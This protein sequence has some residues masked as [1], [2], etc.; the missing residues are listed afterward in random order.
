MPKRTH[1]TTAIPPS[2][3]LT[4]EDVD[5]RM[6]PEQ[7]ADSEALLQGLAD[8]TVVSIMTP[9]EYDRQV[10][11]ARATWVGRD[12]GTAAPSTKASKRV[13]IRLPMADL[14][15]LQARAAAQGIPYQTLLKSV[16]Q[17][18]LTGQLV[19]KGSA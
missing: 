1:T 13:S 7:R 9:A 18:Y 5:A 16:V 4:D 19:P 6:T 14:R 3:A 12:N 2:T 10:A 17:Q 8:G 11:I 15:C